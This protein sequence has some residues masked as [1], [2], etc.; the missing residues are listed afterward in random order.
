MEVITMKRIT[1]YEMLGG[2]MKECRLDID[3]SVEEVAGIMGIK[4]SVYLSYEA[5]QKDIRSRK[6]LSLSHIFNV[7]T[8]Y[9]LGLTDIKTPP[10]KQR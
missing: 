3:M 8:D 6:L 9:L 7:S 1:G 10:Y 2:R 4:K 5:G